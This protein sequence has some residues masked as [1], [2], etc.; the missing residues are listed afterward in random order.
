[1]ESDY[2]KQLN[3]PD[4]SILVFSPGHDQSLDLCSARNLIRKEGE[5]CHRE[6]RTA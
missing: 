4:P 3:V 1:V 6:N 5:R 2:R